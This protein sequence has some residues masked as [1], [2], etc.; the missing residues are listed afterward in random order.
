MSIPF[1]VIETCPFKVI[2][3]DSE[4]EPVDKKFCLWMVND[5]EDGKWNIEFFHDYIWDNIAQTALNQKER[6]ALGKSSFYITE[7]GC[8]KSTHNMICSMPFLMAAMQKIQSN[9]NNEF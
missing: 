7:K 1:N 3:L 9:Q 6:E 8:K 4:L 5:F 2:S